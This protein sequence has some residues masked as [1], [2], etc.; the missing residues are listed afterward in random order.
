M[1][2]TTRRPLRITQTINKL[3]TAAITAFLAL[4]LSGC[5]SA[6]N[7]EREGSISLLINSATGSSGLSAS[8][9]IAVDDFFFGY[10]VSEDLLANQQSAELVFTLMYQ[11]YLD[12]LAVV[13]ALGANNADLSAFQLAEQPFPSL[14]L[15]AT[16]FSGTSGTSEFRG[17]RAGTDYLVVVRAISSGQRLIGY[18]TAGIEAGETS[19]VSLD[20]GGNQTAFNEF[21][22]TNYAVQPPATITLTQ[23]GT[24]ANVPLYVD[25][26]D[27]DTPFPEVSFS[28]WYVESIVFNSQGEEI[29]TTGTRRGVW[30]PLSSYEI[31][32]LPGRSWKIMV[33]TWDDRSDPIGESDSFFLSTT[34]TVPNAGNLTL[35]LASSSG[36]TYVGSDF[37]G[38][39][40]P[41][42]YSGTSLYTTSFLP[43]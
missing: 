2:R 16:F 19:T 13:S 15:Q 39:V 40:P 41:P 22:Q 8:S 14:Q 12:S 35:N 32:V 37:T 27:G 10:V 34:Q 7:A 1:I 26:L 25:I 30:T 29:G 17:L 5:F 18:T 42:P 20:V 28:D 9:S 23:F 3:S 36:S 33:A 43:S 21:R 4:S 11:Q 31:A 6:L 38:F 24:A